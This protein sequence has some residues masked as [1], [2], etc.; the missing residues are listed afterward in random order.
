MQLHKTERARAELKPGIRTLGQRERTL[1]LLADGSKSMQD[2]RPLFDG[3]GE[4]IAL[5][6]LREG[7]LET[8]PGHHAMAASLIRPAPRPAAVALPAGVAVTNTTAQRQN[9]PG[10]ETAQAIKVSADQF[11]GKRSLATTRMF[12]FDICERMF[13][14]RSPAMAERFREALRNA[15]DR[16][17]ML[18]VS[19]DM[20]DEIEKVA[21]HERADSISERLAMLLPLETSAI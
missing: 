19:R 8:H 17:T 16:Q 13:A 14:R 4:Q 20:I 12:L 3:D 21:G 1:L 7:F 15:K 5:R 2:F 11:E 9:A 18:A 6:L 10:P